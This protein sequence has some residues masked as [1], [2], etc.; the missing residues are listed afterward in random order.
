M[1]CLILRFHG[2]LL[3]V[4]SQHV[5]V[6]T[7]LAVFDFL[8][9]ADQ[10]HRREFVTGDRVVVETGHEVPLAGAWLATAQHGKL[11]FYHISQL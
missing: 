7:R 5:G 8:G 4:L 1:L 6:V 2:P 11:L 10:I 9:K 3:L